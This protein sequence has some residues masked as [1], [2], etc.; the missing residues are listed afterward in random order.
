MALDPSSAYEG[1][2]EEGEQQNVQHNQNQAEE[3]F[4]LP[5]H[6]TTISG[7]C[8]NVSD[9]I[10]LKRPKLV[11]CPSLVNCVFAG[12][13]GL[14][15]S[16]SFGDM[17][18]DLSFQMS[19]KDGNDLT[20]PLKLPPGHKEVSEPMDSSSIGD[21]NQ[22]YINDYMIRL[23]LTDDLLHAVFTFLD[24]K[25]LCKAGLVCKQWHAS[26]VHEDFWRSL[27][28][29]N[30]KITSDQVARV[31][32]RYPRAVELH[33]PGSLLD[34]PVHEALRTLK[35][36]EVLTIYHGNLGDAFFSLLVECP[37][38]SHLIV[39]DATLGSGGSQEIHV[40]HESLRHLQVMRCRAIRIFV[41]CPQLET[42][43]LKR[44]GVASANLNCPVLREL[45]VASC[46][47]L[48]DPGIRAAA[49][50]C[51]LLKSLDISNC[52]YVS[53]DTLREIAAV[54]TDLQILDASYCPNI[55]LEAVRLPMLMDLKLHNCEGINAT[56]M[57]AL[58]QCYY[59]EALQLD[60][61]WLLTSVTLD[62]PRLRHISLVNCRKIVDLNLSSPALASINVTSC[63]ILNRVDITS[64]TL[65]K[66][67]LQK[68]Q[69]LTTMTLQCLRLSEVDL[70]ECESL[71]NSIF[72]VFSV[73]GGCPMLG[74]LILDSCESL[75]NVRLT[76]TSLH[77]LSLTGCRGVTSL[78]LACPMLQKV[79]LD[80]CDHLQRA[81]F[82]PVGLL[83]L[84]LGICPYLSELEIRAT[85]MTLLELKGCGVLSQADIN[86]PHL[87][88]LDASFCSLFNDDC[89]DA[90]TAA[91]PSIKSLVLMSCTSIGPGGLL[92][93]QRLSNLTLL[94]LSYTFLTN[95]QPIIDSCP[96][97][98]VLKLQACKYL[99]DT[100]LVPLHRGRALPKL[101]ELD[102]SYGTLSQ[103]AI[104]ELLACCLHLTHVSLNG[105]TN[106]HDLDWRFEAGKSCSDPALH[107]KES[108]CDWTDDSVTE[109]ESSVRLLQILNCVG[110]PNIKK[111][112]IPVSAQCVNLCS[113]NLSLSAN[114]QDVSLVCLNLTTL[115][116]S[117]CLAL[118]ILQLDCPRLA[119]LLLQACGIKEYELECA[120]Y[121]CHLLETLDIRSCPKISSI[122]ISKFRSTCP[123]LKRLFSNV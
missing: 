86:C 121:S 75:S 63:P 123:T 5:S 99:D 53:D 103:S 74:T 91:C 38:L 59:L 4:L 80:G 83:S 22:D 32:R 85:Q 48:S 68:Q 29:E 102:L 26:S 10:P 47:K 19:S 119:S 43:S 35:N 55:S 51:P 60:F 54:C 14:A 104:E 101:S 98:K 18:N 58:S 77:T 109:E 111:V 40:R 2:D 110:C 93:L 107:R 117:N 20:L 81:S 21:D 9:E 122:G 72:E 114:I 31:C 76:S 64:T 84:N 6:N 65:Q 34:N 17:E 42:L 90:A 62:L 12:S 7:F 96:Q 23:D 108:S 106:M 120:I 89:L 116:L 67:V 79:C 3:A 16:S 70:S 69:S 73:G 100:A 82:F 50:S 11:I 33:L 46:H 45:D 13:S 57:A 49:M 30:C 94:D 61:C 44:S 28:F 88:S 105:C 25:A 15:E 37:V 113:L 71:T 36:L 95:L 8:H 52:S 115:N 39:I 66:L 92:A 97:L 24:H 87:Q 118:E 112:V 27:N 78:Q 41:R 56:S 1:L